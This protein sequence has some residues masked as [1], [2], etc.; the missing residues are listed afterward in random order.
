[1]LTLAHATLNIG[2]KRLL[3]DVNIK[4]KPG[5]CVV[6]VGPNGAGKSTALKAMCGDIK[7]TKGSVQLNGRGLSNYK[8]QELAK[9]RAVMCQSYELTFPFNAKEVVTM[10][11]YAFAE[12]HSKKALDNYANKAMA[13]LE[14]CHLTDKCFTQLSGGEQQRVQLARVLSQLFPAL[15]LVKSGQGASPYLL[16]DE[17]T[18]SL[19]LYHQY[20]VMAQAKFAA[21]QGAGVIAVVHDLSLAATFADKVYMLEK[22]KIVRQGSPVQVFSRSTLK[23]TYRVAAQVSTMENYLPFLL[24][25]HSHGQ[26]PNA[27]FIPNALIS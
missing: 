18:S 19:D 21:S 5:E 11:G 8:P 23:Q 4:V 12:H 15:D 9:L 22:G 7:L 26:V 6:L 25:E 2:D 24:I 14:V 16:I 10:G 17:P 20:Q 13:Q 1:M 3:D 27:A